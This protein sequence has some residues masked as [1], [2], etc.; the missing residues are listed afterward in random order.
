[1]GY[2]AYPAVSWGEDSSDY[3]VLINGEEVALNTARVSKIPYNRR[4]PGHQ[5]S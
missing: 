5:R 3:K 4:W 1:M 2:H